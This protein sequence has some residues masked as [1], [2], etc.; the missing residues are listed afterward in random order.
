M[1]KMFLSDLNVT[2]DIYIKKKSH[3]YQ[4]SYH[5]ESGQSWIL[6]ELN[7]AAFPIL[8]SP[9]LYKVTQKNKLFFLEHS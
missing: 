5:P 2:R 1:N 7:C 3:E 4:T 8:E 9:K 6:K